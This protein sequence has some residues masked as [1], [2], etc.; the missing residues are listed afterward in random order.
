[1]PRVVLGCTDVEDSFHATVDAF[2]IAEEFQLPVIVLSDQLI[3]Q[4]RET[5]DATSLVHDVVSRRVPIEPDDSYERYAITDDGV[6][7]MTVPGGK[8]AASS[9]RPR[10]AAGP[11]RGFLASRHRPT[12]AL[13]RAPAFLD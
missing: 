3:A 8:I 12:R 13:P 6:S 2:N 11:G 9:T 4:R 5:I 10:H 1:M 7:P